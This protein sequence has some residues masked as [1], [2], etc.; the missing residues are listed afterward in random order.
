MTIT[1]E[2]GIPAGYTRLASAVVYVSGGMLVICGDPFEAWP[3][4]HDQNDDHPHNC[5]QMGCGSV[6]PHVLYRFPLVLR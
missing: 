6:G 2:S 4:S 3:E 5:D 1:P